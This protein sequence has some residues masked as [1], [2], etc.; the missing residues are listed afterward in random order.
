MEA[1]DWSSDVCSSDLDNSIGNLIMK[2]V[3]STKKGRIALRLHAAFK[4]GG[5]AQVEAAK[6]SIYRSSKI[7]YPESTKTYNTYIDFIKWKESFDKSLE[8]S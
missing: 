7:A 8:D 2:D 5:K 1:S 3:F 6:E 4:I